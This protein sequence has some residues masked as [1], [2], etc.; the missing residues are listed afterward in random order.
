[1]IHLGQTEE[2][3]TEL[4]LNDDPSLEPIYEKLDKHLRVVDRSG[5]SLKDI[6]RYANECNE[7]HFEGQTDVV[8][9]DY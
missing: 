6:E 5:Q 7:Y 9:I 8:M 3:A 1:Q 2:V 4:M